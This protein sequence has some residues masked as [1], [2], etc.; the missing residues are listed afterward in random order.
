MPTA[1]A[2]VAD[3]V[4]TCAGRAAITFRNMELWSKRT[5]NI[6]LSDF[7]RLPGRYY[8]RFLVEDHPGVL[9]EITGV[10]GRHRVSIASIIQH[11]PNGESVGD[12][13]LVP[14]VIMTH[15]AP[16]GAA[17]KAV[18]EIGKLRSVRGTA[19]KMRVLD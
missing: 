11:E 18:E 2:V 3:M 6:R 1:S 5:M 12:V 19:V 7:S 16:E 13:K 8:L 15:Q 17:Q 4:D 14:L 10:L 9:A